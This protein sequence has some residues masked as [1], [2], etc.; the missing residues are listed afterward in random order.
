MISFGG[1]S[2]AVPFGE[3][4]SSVISGPSLSLSFSAPVIQI[5]GPNYS[6]YF[7]SVSS[8]VP[9]GENFTCVFGAAPIV[10]PVGLRI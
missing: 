10:M 6:S 4:Q 1:I 2:I 9:H 7:S 3:Q 5:F 8:A